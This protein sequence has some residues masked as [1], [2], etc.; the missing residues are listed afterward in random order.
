MTARRATTFRKNVGQLRAET[1]SLQKNIPHR[2]SA[3]VTVPEG[4]KSSGVRTVTS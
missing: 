2:R 4:K 1:R 3:S